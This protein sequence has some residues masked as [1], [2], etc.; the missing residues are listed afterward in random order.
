MGVVCV[1]RAI[2]HALRKASG[3][4][5]P[6]FVYVSQLRSDAIELSA[7]A[8]PSASGESEASAKD[9]PA[10]DE[11]TLERGTGGEVLPALLGGGKRLLSARDL[12]AL[13]KAARALEDQTGAAMEAAFAFSGKTL[14]LLGA[15]KSAGSDEAPAGPAPFTV[16][17]QAPTVPSVLPL[18]R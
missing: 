9:S 2:N 15:E 14:Y 17:P 6:A 12:A 7:W 5:H 8:A 13:A 4:C 3:T 10:P 16:A 1:R 11:Y 18:P